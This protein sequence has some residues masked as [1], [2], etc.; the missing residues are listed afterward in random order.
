MTQKTVPCPLCNYQTAQ[1]S[2]SFL[3]PSI[4]QGHCEICGNIWISQEAVDEARRLGKLHVLSA[5]FRRMPSESD[6]W[7]VKRLDIGTIVANTPQYSVLEKLDLA[8]VAIAAKTPEPGQRSQFRAPLDYPLVYVANPQEVF[9]YINELARLEFVRQESGVATVLTPGF[10]RL[11][12]IQKSGRTSAFVFVAMW[13]AEAMNDVYNNAIDPAIRD[14]GYKPI[15]VDREEHVNRIDDEI[16]G[17][18]KASRFLVADF[19]GQRAGVYF[20][21]GMML[22][23]G[24][25]V[26]WMCKDEELK[27]VHF[28]TRQYNFINYKTVEEARKRLYDR[29]MAI[30]GAGP[31]AKSV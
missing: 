25:T 1:V 31:E 22:G 7:M 20:E 16:I 15:R 18:I 26:I 29:I 21:A 9:F 27:D 12:D 8:L 5:W 23:L 3:T 4:Y 14:A 6:V 17:R 11:I 10:K 2:T 24:R 13:F 19:T 30:E 28:D